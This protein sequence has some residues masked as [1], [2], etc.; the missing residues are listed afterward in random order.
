MGEESTN[1]HEGWIAGG[2]TMIGVGVGFFLFHLSIFFFVG[3]I[4][5]G[6]GVGLILEVI[7]GNK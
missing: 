2:M 6:V 1:K 3:A 7:F 4:V 5:A